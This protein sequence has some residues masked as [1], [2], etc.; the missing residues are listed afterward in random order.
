MS[1]MD[2]RSIGTYR[3]LWG[4]R[5]RNAQNPGK[6]RKDLDIYLFT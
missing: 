5:S 1:T 4:H 6:P 3:I 2:L